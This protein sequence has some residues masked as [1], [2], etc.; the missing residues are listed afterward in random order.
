[1]SAIQAKYS[2]EQRDAVIAAA[3]DHQTSAAEVARMA[4][5]GQL[6]GKDGQVEPFEIPASTVRSEARKERRRRAG[7]EVSELAARPAHD[8]VETLRRRL[9]SAADAMLRVEEKKKPERRDA[10]RLRDIGRMVREF[11]AIKAPSDGPSRKPGDRD[12]NGHKPEGATRTGLAA[13]LLRAAQAPTAPDL[14]P[15]ARP[16]EN[17]GAAERSAVDEGAA[18]TKVGERPGSLARSAATMPV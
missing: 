8:A 9:I 13:D 2:Q 10:E 3:V 14:H 12:A 6:H 4:A 1:L 11:A 17:N 16:A 18:E 7:K 5:R 15:K